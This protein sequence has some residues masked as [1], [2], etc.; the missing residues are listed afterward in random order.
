MDHNAKKK[1]QNKKPLYALLIFIGVFSLFI[2]IL[3]RPSLESTAIDEINSCLNTEDVKTIFYKY[4]ND[5]IES[6]EFCQAA[7]DKIKSFNLNQSEIN[8]VRK[9]LPSNTTNLN[10]IIVPDLSNRI[11]DPENNAD[12]IRRD[13]VIINSICESFENNVKTKMNS[14]DKL[15][16][17]ITD[18]KQAGGRLGE[19]ADTIMYDL[20]GFREKI[21]KLYFQ[22]KREQFKLGVQ[23]LYEAAYNFELKNPK[24]G[25]ADFVSYFSTKL[26]SKIQKSTVDDTYRNVLII[27][28]DGYL[29]ATKPNG[30]IVSYIKVNPEDIL[31]TSG[32][33]FKD[34]EVFILEM[35]RKKSADDLEEIKI[36]KWWFKW[37]KSMNIKNFEDDVNEDDVI[38]KRADGYTDVKNRIDEILSKK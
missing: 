20:S 1:K 13:S 31:E 6:Q 38:L 34:L 17:D 3:V 4:K 29:E 23:K 35:N 10:V 5:L 36:K 11:I 21:N 15:L 19:L 2:Y 7:R 12:Q 18:R 30:E 28:T 14:N 27:L 32:V 25:G 26:K 37:L 9:W 22:D 33:R 24:G 16:I 8:E